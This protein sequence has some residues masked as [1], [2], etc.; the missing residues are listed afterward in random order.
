MVI[1]ESVVQEKLQDKQIVSRVD[2]KYNTCYVVGKS[3]ENFYTL[4]RFE[5]LVG[6]H[7]IVELE[8][9]NADAMINHLLKVSQ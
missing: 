6:T 7:C 2:G 4:Y 1:N 9:A 3:A 8:N 5:A